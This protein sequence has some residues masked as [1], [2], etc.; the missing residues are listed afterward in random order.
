MASLTLPAALDAHERV[1][2]RFSALLRTA[3]DGGLRVPHLTWTV[4]E[5]GAHVLCYLRRYP[6]M[7]AGVSAGWESL[8]AGEAENARLLA[9]V[10]E[11]DPQ[12]IA[13][14]IDLAAPAFREAFARYTGDLAPWHAGLRIP[15]AAMVGMMMGDALVHGWDIA[16][17]L[18]GRWTI[19]PSDACLSFAA[20]APVLPY[21]VDEEAA[22]GFSASYGI[23]LR[24]GPA[25]TFTFAE[26]QLTVV[27]GRPPRADCRI[28]AEPVAYLLTAYGRVPVWRP[29][30]RGSLLVYGR[31]PWLGLKL[32]SLV[33]AV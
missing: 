7:L 24:G 25:F 4:G 32:S 16:T 28:S 14:A 33:V 26:G 8:G 18:G 23:Q 15:P 31:R 11:R 2:G 30:V 1:T 10:P 19:D 27:E 5:T 29:A 6:D 12:E 17:A 3:D 13:D 22:R 20:T 21:A 9:D